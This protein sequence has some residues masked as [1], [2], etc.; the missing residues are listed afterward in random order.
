MAALTF[1]ELEAWKQGMTLVEQCYRASAHFPN[2][3]LYGLTSQLRRAAISI[4]ANVAEGHCRRTT[5][6]Y[7]HHV[8]V[9]PGSEGE[10]ETCLELCIRLGYVTG[11]EGT[12]LLTSA[13][14]V[15]RLLH[16]LYRSLEARLEKTRTSRSDL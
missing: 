15:G 2:T 5:K 9:A 13:G 6:A 16:G 12:A 10:L 8:S 7:A 1:R 14:S 3:E 11:G 4:P